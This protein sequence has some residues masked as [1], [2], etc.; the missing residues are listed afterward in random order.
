MD[1]LH[2]MKRHVFVPLAPQ[3]LY[4]FEP[5]FGQIVDPSVNT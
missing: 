4:F 3:Q 1:S 2:I 5:Y